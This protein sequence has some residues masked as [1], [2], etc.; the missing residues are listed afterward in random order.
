MRRALRL[1]VVA[2]M[3]G[4]GAVALAP[5][6]TVQASTTLGYNG[7]IAFDST[8]ADGHTQVYSINP[9]GSG[10]TVET[11]V[12]S[13]ITASFSAQY[14]P[15]GAKLAY[16]QELTSVNTYY[17][18][19][20]GVRD[21]AGNHDSA[22]LLGNSSSQCVDVVEPTWSPSAD[23]AFACQRLGSGFP[24]WQAEN[25]IWATTTDYGHAQR[26]TF[27]DTIDEWPSYSPN[28]SKI[29]FQSSVAG[30][31]DF[32][33][34]SINA[35]DGSARTT[36][37]SVA[38]PAGV[39]NPEY[40]PDGTKILYEVRATADWASNELWL[41]NADGS[42]KTRLTNDSVWEGF[43]TWSPDGRKILFSYH[44][45]ACSC[46]TLATMA[47]T[48]SDVPHIIGGTWNSGPWNNYAPH[49]QQLPDNDPPT[50]PKITGLHTFTTSSSATVHL[51]S[52]DA[53]AGVEK[54]FV[55]SRAVAWND[56][57]WGAWS[58]WST[59]HATAYTRSSLRQGWTYCF[60]AAAEDRVGN[61]SATSSPVCT[62]R[63]LDDSAAIRSAGWSRVSS[64]AY[65]AGSALRTTT[66]GATL[67]LRRFTGRR[68]A[69]LVRTCSTCGSV[70]V[71]VGGITYTTRS[72]YSAR[73]H[74][75]VRLTF[76]AL[77]LTTATV[78]IVNM[79]SKP[80]F[81][82]GIGLSRT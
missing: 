44:S 30:G 41:M 71:S 35:A 29:V 38:D 7:R 51:A 82:D 31:H 53:G 46:D 39:F 74:Y 62:S 50:T 14:A 2:G 67:T 65:Y 49:W 20:L 16:V 76:P 43:P 6:E 52:T 59:V 32:K 27:T 64:S 54:Y 61:Y 72:T 40:S 23:I 26:L 3:L 73:P 48:S 33:I 28:G 77:G 69:L 11:A 4:A 55:Q 18:H 9:D 60:R 19:Y 79:S 63:I 45:T 42:G 34:E 5:I 22:P 66:K 47:P 81:V 10:L 57:T 21:A 8:R 24:N 1:V 37:A 78:R 56:P 70:R 80:L 58:S 75:R 15:D 12:S 17:R 36:L 68:V 25:N 13:S